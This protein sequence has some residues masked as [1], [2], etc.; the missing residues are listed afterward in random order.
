MSEETRS[1]SASSRNPGL[2]RQLINRGRLVLRLMGDERVPLLLKGM[3]LFSLLYLISPIDLIP[4]ALIV[5]L[6]PVGAVGAVDDV[7]VVLLLLNFFISL[8][9]PGVV[10]EH[11]RELSAQGG[12]RAD[13][14]PSPDGEPPPMVEGFYRIVDDEES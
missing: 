7:A 4:E 11:E 5:A 13:D 8:A 3:P 6:G 9:P 1:T 10:A 14:A 12:W 2:I